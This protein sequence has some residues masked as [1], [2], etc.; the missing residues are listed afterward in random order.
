[1][2]VVGNCPICKQEQKL[3]VQFD[4]VTSSFELWC[5][6]CVFLVDRVTQ[7]QSDFDSFLELGWQVTYR[8]AYT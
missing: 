1:M 7:A 8:S 2:Q 4:E 3:Q 6:C 5:P